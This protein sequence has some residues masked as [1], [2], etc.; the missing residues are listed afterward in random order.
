M[1]GELHVCTLKAHL[2]KRENAANKTCFIV[3]YTIILAPNTWFA[4]D[5]FKRDFSY[6]R[7]SIK[8]HET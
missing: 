4:A 8:A 1:L 5:S 6:Q 7:L 3:F 2:F